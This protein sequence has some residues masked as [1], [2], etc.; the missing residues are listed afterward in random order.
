M[1]KKKENFSRF[2]VAASNAIKLL[3]PISFNKISAIL[4]WQV[5]KNERQVQGRKKKEEKKKKRKIPL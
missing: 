3:L 1:K 5:P 2:A 4:R